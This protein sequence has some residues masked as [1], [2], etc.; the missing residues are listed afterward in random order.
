MATASVIQGQTLEL[1]FKIDDYLSPNYLKFSREL[2]P[3]VS[4]EVAQN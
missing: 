4:L 3:F 1:N 2:I